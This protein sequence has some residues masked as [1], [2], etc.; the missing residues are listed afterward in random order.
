M[1][2][3]LRIGL[4]A[5]STMTK[6]VALR[7][8]KVVACAITATGHDA[9]AAAKKVLREVGAGKKAKCSVTGYGR[10]LVG[11][12]FGFDVLTEI[13]AHAIGARM[14]MPGVKLVVDVGGQDTKVIA[15][16]DDGEVK[17]FL[18]NDRC[19]AGTGRFL[20]MLAGTLGMDFDRFDEAAGA[21]GPEA[22]LTNTCAVFAQSEVVGLLA[23]G[24]NRRAIAKGCVQSIAKRL[25]ADVGRLAGEAREALFCGGGAELDS[26]AA[27]VSAATRVRMVVTAEARYIGAIGAALSG[28]T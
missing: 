25:A 1:K 24:V 15:I 18:L 7:G 5:G 6:A 28:K 23:K 13:R 12:E 22:T 20:E 19:A 21:P 17:D 3:S 4:D 2:E 8:Q 9:V 27:A 10:H 11:K 14:V 26:L 16:G